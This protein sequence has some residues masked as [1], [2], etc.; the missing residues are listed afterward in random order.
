MVPTTG[1]VGAGGCALIVTLAEGA[2]I[3]PS[4]LV[5]VKVNVPAG[6][7]ETVVLVP[8]PVVVTAPGE[9]VNVQV[10]EDGNPLSTTLPVATS[11]VGWVIVPTTGGAG[12]AFTLNVY[13]A[14]AGVQG[15]PSGLLVVTVMLTILSA[16]PAAGV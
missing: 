5:T 11:H 7:P 1:A 10:P 8:V 3:H 14:V 9:R 2:E 15:S 6:I 4:A 13:V 16:S 12:V